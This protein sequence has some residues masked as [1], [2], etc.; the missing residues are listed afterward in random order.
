MQGK[1][2]SHG[3][4]RK[5]FKKK[6]MKEKI[7]GKGNLLGPAGMGATGTAKTSTAGTAETS[8]VGIVGTV[9]ASAMGLAEKG[10]ESAAGIGT[11]GMAGASIPMPTATP[12]PSKVS[13]SREIGI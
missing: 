13:A 3:I 12:G 4:G 11:T 5:D 6:K 9:E 7:K 2:R 10:A 8:I 1:M